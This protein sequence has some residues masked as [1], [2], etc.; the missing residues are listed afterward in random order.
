MHEN[1]IIQEIQLTTHAFLLNFYKCSRH[2]M[3]NHIQYYS[4]HKINKEKY[5]IHYI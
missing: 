2:N 5:I 4:N 3:R 1:S